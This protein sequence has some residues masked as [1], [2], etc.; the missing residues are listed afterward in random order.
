MICLPNPYANQM[1]VTINKH[2][3]MTLDEQ[4]AIVNALAFYHA[5]HTSSLDP[6][7]LEQYK[8]AYKEDSYGGN[9]VDQLATKIA[10]IH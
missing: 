2:L 10:N 7:L 1:A 9:F 8:I 3:V 5:Y 4:Y 6:N